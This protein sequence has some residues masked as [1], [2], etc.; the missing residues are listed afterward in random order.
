MNVTSKYMKDYS[1]SY[2]VCRMS[3][4]DYNQKAEDHRCLLIYVRQVPHQRLGFL[5]KVHA[6]V[7]A[8]AVCLCVERS[9]TEVC[10]FIAGGK[11]IVPE[12]V[13]PLV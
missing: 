6:F 2:I 1:W 8:V 4:A 13:Q 5:R 11:P 3:F 12:D 7:L 10:N 9:C